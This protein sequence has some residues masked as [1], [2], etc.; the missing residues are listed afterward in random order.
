MSAKHQV[1]QGA[2]CKCQFGTTPDKL[3]VLTQQKHYINDKDAKE[4]L[5]ATNVDIGMTFEKNTFGQCKL[6][7]TTGGYLPCIPAL[8][9]W[10]GQYEKVKYEINGGNPLLEDSKGICAISGSPSIA[11]TFHGQTAEPTQKNVENASE[12]V[13][14]ELF[15]AIDT[16]KYIRK[17]D[18]IEP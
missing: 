10:T 8:T 12:E 4:K 2:I 11:I 5:V 18:N 16:R 17:T 9:K 6:Q 7:P 3:M 13:V 14:A 1:C 15:A